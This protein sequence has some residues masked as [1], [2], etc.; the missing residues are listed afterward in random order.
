MRTLP[1]TLKHDG[2]ELRQLAREGSV[3]LYG[4]YRGER[5]NSYEV[6]LVQTHTAHTWP[7]GK[8]TEAGEHYPRSEKWGD[9]G[10]TFRVLET[11]QAHMAR[12]VHQAQQKAQE[13]LTHAAPAE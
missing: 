4:Q 1:L 13:V 3:A 2:F 9:A 11:A 6:I 7:N 12:L 8:V 10:W 5:L